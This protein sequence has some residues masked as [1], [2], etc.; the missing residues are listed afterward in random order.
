MHHWNYGWFYSNHIGRCCL[1]WTPHKMFQFLSSSMHAIHPD[2]TQQ[3]QLPWNLL[4]SS[5]DLKVSKVQNDQNAGKSRRGKRRYGHPPSM[6][7]CCK[8]RSGASETLQP[9]GEQRK[10]GQIPRLDTLQMVMDGLAKYGQMN[11]RVDHPPA[12]DLDDL[13]SAVCVFWCSLA[14]IRLCPNGDLQCQQTS[15]GLGWPCLTLRG[16]PQT[17]RDCTRRLW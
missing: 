4:S 1:S 10:R 7:S 16:R 11:H 15:T 5:K 12:S 2:Q 17:I 14:V 9:F 13:V 6:S 8:K 3:W